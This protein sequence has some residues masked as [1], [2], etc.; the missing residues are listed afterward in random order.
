MAGNAEY[1]T[2]KRD[3]K[4]R[5][6]VCWDCPAVW[7]DAASG[8]CGTCRARRGLPGVREYRSPSDA[9]P[10]AAEKREYKVTVEAA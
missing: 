6:P 9:M 4:R 10:A 2:R 3:S 1:T 8:L 5:R 7:P